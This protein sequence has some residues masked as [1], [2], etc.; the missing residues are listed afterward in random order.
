MNKEHNKYE[1]KAPVSKKP[2]EEFQNLLF[3]TKFNTPLNSQIIIDAIHK[4]VL[5]INETRYYIEEMED[6]SCHCFRHTFAT[7]CFEAGIQPKTVQKYL[8]HATLQ[9]T[10]D[11]Y[12]AV[13][14]K[15]LSSEM[16]K[17]DDELEKIS[18]SGEKLIDSRYKKEKQN[19][20]ITFPGNTLVV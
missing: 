9:M 16:E 5:T 11:L 14:P 10:M 6:F 12:T 2:K 4:I 19:D 17:L 1:A 20:V 3:T 13:M 18:Q 8:G 7:R 15:H